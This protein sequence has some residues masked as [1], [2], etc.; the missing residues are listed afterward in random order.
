MSRHLLKKIGRFLWS[1]ERVSCSARR[2]RVLG[3]PFRY[4][5]GPPVSEQLAFAEKQRIA[6][7]FLWDPLW[8]VKTY[9]HP[10]NRH[11]AL[12]YWYETGWAR[13]EN[14]SPYLNVAFYRGV[15]NPVIAYLSKGKERNFFPDNKNNFKSPKDA[16]RIARYLEY[17]KTR[18][19]KSVIYTCISNDY[20]DIG[21]LEAYGYVNPEWDY[22]CYTD[23][24]EHISRG[25][26]GIWEVR[27]LQ[28]DKSDVSRNNR[29]HKMHPHLLFPEHDESIYID[30]NINILTDFLFREIERIG[31][32]FVLPRHFKNQCIYHEYQDVLAGR[33]DDAELIERE[34]RLV[35]Q[36]GMPTN[37]GFMENNILYRRHHQPEIVRM[38]EE[39]WDMLV[40][41]AKRDQ[42]SLAYLFWKNGR[43]VEDCTFENS[44]LRI[45]DFYVF[46]H[47]K[48]RN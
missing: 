39:W 11:Q 40:N 18:Q 35:E 24:Q 5:I 4:N 17:K 22:V 3:I 23:N 14:P 9:G 45:H 26:I 8:Y 16:E 48:G 13:G 25:Q 21:E 29:W 10:F 38:M 37:Y 7:S 12:D 15:V 44:R 30:A 6:E 47:K 46:G 36:A 2:V 42:L 31:G 20:D 41:Y 19:S 27:P 43:R 34:R 1:R 28:Y 33:L 32:D